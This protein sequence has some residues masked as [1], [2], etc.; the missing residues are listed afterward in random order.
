MPVILV[1]G[2]CRQEEQEFKVILSYIVGSGWPERYVTIRPGNKVL[3]PGEVVA[4][5]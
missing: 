3:K 1:L 4:S 2:G 5:G